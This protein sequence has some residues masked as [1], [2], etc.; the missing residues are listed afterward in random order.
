[1]RGLLFEPLRRYL[2]DEW[3]RAGLKNKDANIA[4]NTASM[5]ARHF[6]SD[7][8]WCMPTESHYRSLQ[9]YANR[10]GGEYLR[11]EY[12]SLRRPF[13]VNKDVPY[14]DVWEFSTVKASPDKHPCEKPVELMSHI[15]KSSTREN[16]LV[17][18]C[19]MGS[20]TTGVA[21]KLLNRRFLGI[22]KDAGYIE[23]AKQRI[24]SE[25]EMV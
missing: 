13:S 16:A 8:Q 23:I 17:L 1:L 11:R 9:K 19:F 2:S 15:I 18:D 21:C 22:E 6:F 25:V 24:H 4:C 12:E 20:G 14:T 5:A 3:K 10:T 7:S